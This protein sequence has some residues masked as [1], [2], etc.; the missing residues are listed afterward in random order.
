MH[1]LTHYTDCM[2]S[3]FNYLAAS[4]AI[5]FPRVYQCIVHIEEYGGYLAGRLFENILKFGGCHS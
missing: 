3:Q 2:H 4:F 1:A 5:A